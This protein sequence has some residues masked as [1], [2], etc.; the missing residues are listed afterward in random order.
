M[1]GR[2]AVGTLKLPNP[3][4]A[5]R[6]KY[7]VG[8]RQDLR[9]PYR[10]ISLT[11]THHARGVEDNPPLPVYDCSGPFS[12]P[13]AEVDLSKG[14]PDVRSIWIDE[15]GDTERLPALSSQYSRERLHDLLVHHLRFPSVPRPRRAIAGRNVTQMHYARRGVVTPEMEF[16]ALRE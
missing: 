9:V 11:P 5:S 3:F 15:R 6:K 10:E 7:V 12:K 13:D 8:S 16:V 2:S 4:P 1:D 14:L